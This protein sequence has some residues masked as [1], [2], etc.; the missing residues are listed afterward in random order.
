MVARTAAGSGSGGWRWWGRRR[1][2]VAAAAAE[3]A[4]VVGVGAA[5]DKASWAACIRRI[6][7]LGGSWYTVNLRENPRRRIFRGIILWEV[8]IIKRIWTD[9]LWRRRDKIWTILW[10]L[11]VGSRSAFVT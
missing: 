4:W 1:G 10:R 6:A 8:R 11:P 9:I 3:T 7:V 2:I 5:E